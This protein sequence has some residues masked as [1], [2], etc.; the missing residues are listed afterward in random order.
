MDTSSAIVEKSLEDTSVF[1]GQ[2]A[3]EENDSIQFSVKFNSIRY[4]QSA[5]S[6]V[7]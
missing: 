2:F 4:S 5:D 1:D 6:Y 7:N 3:R